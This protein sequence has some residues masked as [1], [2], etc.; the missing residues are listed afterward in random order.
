VIRGV[1]ELKPDEE[2]SHTECEFWKWLSRKAQNLSLY[3][4]FEELGRWY[5]KIHDIAK[6][7]VTLH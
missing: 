3:Q 6:Q 5:E 2:I 1:K 7:V 4:N